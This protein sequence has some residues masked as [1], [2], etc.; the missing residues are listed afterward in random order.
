MSLPLLF[1]K[2]II[3]PFA[4]VVNCF[5]GAHIWNR[6]TI[7][8]FVDQCIIHYTMRAKLVAGEVFET[9]GPSL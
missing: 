3:Q 9:S 4:V 8:G 7:P 5:L 6:T 1:K 2:L